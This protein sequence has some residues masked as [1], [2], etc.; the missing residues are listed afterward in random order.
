MQLNIR[1][2]N[3]NDWNILPIWWDKWPK[4]KTPPRDF[5]PDNGLNGLMVEKGD[6]PIL[7]GFLY[8]TNSKCVLLEWI[9][10]D[11][12]Y[13]ESDR[14]DALQLL[15]QGAENVC[16]SQGYKYMFFVGKHNNLINTFESLGWNVDRTPSYELI[17][18]IN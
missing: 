8:T 6:T 17:K 13:R 15:I 7:A 5:L 4:W 9:I 1:R 10:S 12:D 3:E 11:P 14:Q 18:T 16:K 2:L